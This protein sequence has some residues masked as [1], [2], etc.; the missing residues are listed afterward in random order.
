MEFC[1]ASTN[2]VLSRCGDRLDTTGTY[3]STEF[4]QEDSHDVLTLCSGAAYS[5]FQGCQGGLV[6]EKCLEEL[7]NEATQLCK[8]EEGKYI[9]EDKCGEYGY[10]YNSDTEYCSNGA[11]VAEYGVLEDERD[12]QKY[13]TVVI[14]TQTWMAENL[15]YKTKEGSVCY[16][17]NEANCDIYG[18]LYQRFTALD[19]AASSNAIPSGVKGVCPEGWHIPSVAEWNVLTAHVDSLPLNTPANTQGKKLKARDGWTFTAAAVLNFGTDDFG[20]RI[21]PAGTSTNGT[22][23]GS[24]GTS[25]QFVTAVYG[26]SLPAYFY[27]AS[28]NNT[29]ASSDAAATAWRSVRCVKDLQ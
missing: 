16:S 25:A 29:F 4:C 26:A 8:K 6:M 19:T 24:L 15:N 10:N 17:N 14:G 13:K 20:F 11:T 3:K 23:F 27:A 7:F 2:K 12:K 21:L 9:V 22:S 28:V 18:R 1:Q 5:E